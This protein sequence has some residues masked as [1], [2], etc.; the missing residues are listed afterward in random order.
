MTV[1]GSGAQTLQGFQ[2]FRGSIAFMLREAIAGVDAVPLVHTRVAV[3]FGE[4]RGGGDGN[5]LCVA[6]DQRLLLDGDVEHHGVDQ[7]VVWYEGQLA[8]RGG[9]GLPTGLKDIP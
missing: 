3:R 8:E 5:A 6:L 9:H 1:Q 4:Y 2:V 7:K